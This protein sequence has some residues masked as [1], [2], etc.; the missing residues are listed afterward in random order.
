MYF[1]ADLSSYR[2]ISL[3][4]RSFIKIAAGTGAG[5]I[6][7]VELPLLAPRS[8]EAAVFAANPFVR[9]AP[10]NTVTVLIKHLD[11]GQGVA[12][13]LS[14]LVAE[15]L[16]ADHAQMRAEFSPADAKLYANLLFG[17]IQGTGGSSS[18]ANSFEQYRKAGAVARAMLIAAAAKSWGV[19]SAEITVAKGILTHSAGKSATFGEMAEAASAAPVPED[20]M[21]KDPS[22]F[23][24]IGKSF[25]RIDTEAK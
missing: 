16:D 3:S 12:T 10:D 13:G 17:T 7:G 24:F 23:V 25:P 22:K 1:P 15:E 18:I 4:R 2:P 14:T 11:M 20:V 6:I 21:L 5:L 9:I 8:A 19:V